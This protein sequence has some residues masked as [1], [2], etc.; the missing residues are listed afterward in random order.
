[1]ILSLVYLWTDFLFT[2]HRAMP[3][4]T[5]PQLRAAARLVLPRRSRIL[6]VTS[7][8][9]LPAGDLVA[10]VGPEVSHAPPCPQSCIPVPLVQHRGD[11]LQPHLLRSTPSSVRLH[12]MQ[13]VDVAGVFANA[14]NNGG[15]AREGRVE[16]RIPSTAT[17]SRNDPHR[18]LGLRLFVAR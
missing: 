11:P 3:A 8:D 17:D 14:S 15:T 18:R 6:P 12:S 5:L 9:T 4:T 10:A 1:M 7:L 13:S 16:M 2:A